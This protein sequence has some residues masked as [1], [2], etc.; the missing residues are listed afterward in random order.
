MAD[1]EPEEPTAVPAETSEAVKAPPRPRIKMLPK[2]DDS[3][4]KAQT[5]KLNEGI[6]AQKKRIEEIREIINN[7]QNGRQG[8]SGEQ[9]GL[10]NRLV[11]L[12]TQWQGELNLKQQIRAELDNATRAR[13]SL[14]AQLREMKGKLEYM[15]VGNI[16]EQVRRL[17]HKM[18]HSSQSLQEEKK[19][20]DDMKRLK[21]S[22]STVQQYNDRFEKLS[23]DDEGRNAIVQR[24]QQAETQLKSI[25]VE[26]EQL[27]SQLGEMRSK[28]AEQ[29]SD[30]PALIQE[31]EDCRA[32]INEL[33]S[34]IKDIRADLKVK[35]DEY[36][37]RQREFRQQQ[38]EE[39]AERRVHQQQEWEERQAERKARQAEMAGEP[40]DKEVTLC[41]Q[42]T[43]Y[44]IK[45]KP[46]AQSKSTAA[47]TAD[48][49]IPGMQIFKKKDVENAYAGLEKKGKGK[50][51]KGV[52]A[53]SKAA[54]GSQQEDKKLMHS[55]DMLGAF[56]TLKVEVPLSTSKVEETLTGIQGRKEYY[57][58]KRQSVKDGTYDAE[59]D[60]EVVS[61]KGKAASNSGTATT[62]HSPPA[63]NGDT[64][65]DFEHVDKEEVSGPEAEAAIARI[66]QQAPSTPQH[67][68]T[69]SDPHASKPTTSALAEHDA[70]FPAIGAMNGI[71]AP[72]KSGSA[73]NGSASV[74]ATIGDESTF[75]PGALDTALET[76]PSA[77]SVSLTVGD[78]GE[79]V[80]LALTL[81][82]AESGSPNGT[83]TPASGATSVPTPAKM[84]Y[85][86]IL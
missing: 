85:R 15:T 38:Q 68:N 25:K 80:L 22:R 71:A 8:R 10:K 28:E 9:Q 11:E 24:L 14:R 48:V 42:L 12:K 5:G 7:K 44:L 86:G 55:L 43:S 49:G 67:G 64:I 79:D 57:L 45:F 83:A 70:A 66:T 2:P 34:K 40:F 26:E 18:A 59:Q 4:V 56:A 51:G 30:I 23:S 41:E 81:D 32:V 37:E 62:S 20:L 36:Y 72:G 65:Q 77:V 6:Q 31:R 61:K 54:E 69:P 73:V 75:A 1:T 82:G 39:Q 78:E 29:K 35:Q 58:K 60:P 13:D 76:M 53:A 47:S 33:Y 27:R 63:A 46:A 50:K 74:V 52:A 84:S 19:T 21:A 16:D 17:E 3:E